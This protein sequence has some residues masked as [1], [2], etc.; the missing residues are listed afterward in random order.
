MQEPKRM[1]PSVDSL[2]TEKTT[3]GAEL[4]Y[5]SSIISIKKVLRE[6]F[7]VGK[8]NAPETSTQA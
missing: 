2:E 6:S 5:D 8:T 7:V 1:A 4:I 3:S